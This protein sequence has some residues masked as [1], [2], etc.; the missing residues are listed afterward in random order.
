MLQLRF[1]L[2]A[3]A[4]LTV[5]AISA[6]RGGHDFQT[7]KKYGLFVCGFFVRMFIPS[8]EEGIL[9]LGELVDLSGDCR[10]AI[11]SMRGKNRNH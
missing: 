11:R 7:H 3:G 10:K 1:G 9:I 5:L 4:H 8:G 6:A 2:I